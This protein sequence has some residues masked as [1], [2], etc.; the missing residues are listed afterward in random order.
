MSCSCLIKVVHGNESIDLLYAHGCVGNDTS[1]ISTTRHIHRSQEAA[2]IPL[3][4]SYPTLLG[5]VD[6]DY[7]ELV[8]AVAAEID[9]SRSDS[10]AEM[11]ET[12][13]LDQ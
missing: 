9:S 5:F 1:P 13:R 12:D 6:D 10:V 7:D 8:R 11:N 3:P 2:T 4:T